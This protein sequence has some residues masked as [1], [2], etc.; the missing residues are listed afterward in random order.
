MPWW[1]PPTAKFAFLRPL[2]TASHYLDFLLWPSQPWL[3]HLQNTLWF[4]LAT[5]LAARLYFRM[6]PPIA[7]ILAACMYAVDEAHVHG[8]SWIAG[9]NTLMT[10]VFVLLTLLAWNRARRSDGQGFVMLAAAC[11]L[12]AHACSEGSY[13]AWPY[14]VGYE[15]AYPA[16]RTTLAARVKKLLPL[17]AATLAW[18]SCSS[19]AGFGVRGSDFYIDLR[20]SPRLFAEFA[21]QRFP[22]LLREQL[23]LPQLHSELLPHNL[24]A[25]SI[26][27]AYTL[28]AML[29]LLSF[30]L[31]R[32]SRSARMFGLGLFGSTLLACSADAGPRIFFITSIG[33]HAVLAELLYACV[34]EARRPSLG[35]SLFVATAVLLGSIH[36]PL[37]LAAQPRAAQFIPS[38]EAR[39]RKHAL[40]MQTLS[41]AH[42]RVVVLNAPHPLEVGFAAL[43]L[44]AY[45]QN[46]HTAQVLG[47]SIGPVRLSR[48]SERSLLL[49]PVAGYL[50]GLQGKTLDEADLA[51]QKGRVISTQLWRVTLEEITPEGRPAR[52]RFD[53]AA[54]DATQTAWATWNPE[55]D[56]FESARLPEVGGSL[57]LPGS[58]TPDAASRGPLMAAF[59][60]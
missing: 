34:R 37:A 36:L 29:G 14:L 51:F 41:G 38:V 7:A 44:G 17:L 24:Q 25:L 9:R 11:L 33:A 55:H 2:A 30:G 40:D 32:R 6:L 26:G 28:L 4:A 54:L 23:L 35:Q 49:E 52:V 21:L 20:S 12:C 57:W 50:E 59:V 13:M 43:Y 45:T 19:L 53:F 56:R 8:A 27:T 10:A 46:Q 1:T 31:L 60:D 47:A 3:M 16:P 5:F 39:V 15:L 42:A 58:A 22:Q 48:P 18:L